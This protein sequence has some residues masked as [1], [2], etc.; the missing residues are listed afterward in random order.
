MMSPSAIEPVVQVI[1]DDPAVLASLRLLLISAGLQVEAYE[2]AEAFLAVAAELPPGCIITDM[3][4][5]GMGGLE[6]MA[7][8]KAMAVPHPVVVI[9]GHGDVAL[10]VEA[11]KQGAVDLLEKP[12]SDI[13]LLRCIRAAIDSQSSEADRDAAI[14]AARE[15]LASLS[16]RERE[17]VDGLV[18][19]KSNKTIA[20]DLGIGH[21]TVEEYRANVMTKMRVSNLS[22]L[23]QV[24]LRA[25][26]GSK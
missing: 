16:G 8:L 11:M 7:R 12:F 2:T 4:M 14:V 21:R 25:G 1:D 23:V 22:M 13:A 10:A 3:R 9:T 18:L 20:R 24:V 6:L 15:G 19:G 26:S 17:V 5:P